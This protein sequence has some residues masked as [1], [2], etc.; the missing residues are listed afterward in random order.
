MALL[1]SESV[2]LTDEDF[3]V[4][5]PECWSSNLHNLGR[6][7]TKERVVAL[8]KYTADAFENLGLKLGSS[9]EIPSVWN[10]RQVKD[11]WAYLLRD[12]AA[13][14]RMQPILA[15]RLDLATRV[16]APADHFRHC[17]FCIR[18]SNDSLAI[19]IRLSCYATL[20]VANLIGRADAEAACS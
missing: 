10:G 16:K 5:R 19:G 7:R 3:D 8:A 17:L 18:L 15:K 4:Y 11:Q 6:M 2:G 1:N 13:Q 12:D 9:S 14:R 20:D